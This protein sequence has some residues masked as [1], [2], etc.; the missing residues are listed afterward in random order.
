MDIDHR[1]SDYSGRFKEVLEFFFPANLPHWKSLEQ[2][3]GVRIVAGQPV[4]LQVFTRGFT[5]GNMQI[6][7]L[8]GDLGSTPFDWTVV[9]SS[10]ATPESPAPPMPGSTDGGQTLVV[11]PFE[12]HSLVMGAL[13]RKHLRRAGYEVELL[14]YPD[15]DDAPSW[16]Y[17]EILPEISTENY[18]RIL[19]L[20]DRPDEGVT[21]ALLGLVE[22]WRREGVAVSILNRHE[23][24]WSRLPGLVALGAEVMLGGDWAYFW[25]Q[26]AG[27]VDLN[28]ARIAA[29]CTRD[30]TQSCVGVTPQERAVTEGLLSVVHGVL[31]K[32]PADS[33]RAWSA[34]AE[35]VLDHIAA[36]DQ[37][38]F[39]CQ[40]KRFREICETEAGC[41]RIE[42]QV[43]VFDQPPGEIPQVYYWI[44]ETAIEAGGRVPERGLRYNAP[45]ALAWWPAEDA[46][47]L[48][49]ISHWRE[50]QAV[51]VR[52]L[53]PS[54]VGPPPQGD[55]CT[56]R[57]RMS[58]QQAAVV[59]PAILAAVDQSQY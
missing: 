21:P 1:R 14:C 15:T 8:R 39:A 19:I 25:G 13:S 45:Y 29:L 23:G 43:V 44:M 53:Y 52:L 32:P 46:V 55:E 37:D 2:I 54:G 31:S 11:F 7:M 12:A 30:P 6:D 57:I 50:E 16:L 33:T 9:A 49:A 26:P 4:M 47:E 40:A 58:A 27:E 5:T 20:G 38:H 59:I 36:D 17:R 51:P 42:G 48:L 28:W 3:L 35:P 18:E 41:G 34:A 10:V 22:R 24:N 56:V